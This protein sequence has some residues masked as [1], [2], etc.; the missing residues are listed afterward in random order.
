[1]TDRTVT[2]TDPQSEKTLELPVVAGSEGDP[3]IDITRLNPEMGYF[4][5]DPGYG[6]TANCK[7][8]ITFIDGANGI[9]RYRGYPIEQLAERSSFMEVAFLLLYGELPT[10]SELQDFKRDITYHTMVH[11]K[12]NNFIS[13][14]HYDAH[15]MAILSGVV[16]SMAGF[17]QQNLDVNNPDHRELAAK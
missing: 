1:M 14:F 7:S 15:P 5:Y 4:T 17:Y 12:V 11:E 3:T 9:L 2:L 6:T 10:E 8:D 16:A 13:G